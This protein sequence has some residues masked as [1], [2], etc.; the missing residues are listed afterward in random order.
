MYGYL[1]SNPFAGMSAG[2]PKRNSF[3]NPSVN[4][5]TTEEI[6]DVIIAFQNSDYTLTMH[7]W[8]SFGF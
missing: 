1:E 3:Q 8:L 5:F 4:A 6:L 2:M 7:L